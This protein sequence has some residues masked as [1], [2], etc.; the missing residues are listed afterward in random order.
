MMSE[1]VKF[2]SEAAWKAASHQD[3]MSPCSGNR[4]HLSVP[5]AGCS[6][7][8][9]VFCIGS[10]FDRFPCFPKPAWRI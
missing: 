1:N 2:S 6:A 3:A 7:A 4:N 5:K 8:E 9:F 10:D